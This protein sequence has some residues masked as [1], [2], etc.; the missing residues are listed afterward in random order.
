MVQE[1]YWK[2]ISDAEYIT[3]ATVLRTLHLTSVIA[4]RVL[5]V[6]TVLST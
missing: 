4:G 5:I 1:D 2:L 3:V 6:E